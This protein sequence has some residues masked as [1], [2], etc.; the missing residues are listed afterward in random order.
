MVIEKESIVE[1]ITEII[2][3]SQEK[4]VCECVNNRKNYGK[5]YRIL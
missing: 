4:S 1:R 2:T 3:E 5:Y